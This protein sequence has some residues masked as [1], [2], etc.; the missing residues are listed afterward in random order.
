MFDSGINPNHVEFTGRIAAARLLLAHGTHP[1]PARP[2]GRRASDPVRSSTPGWLADGPPPNFSVAPPPTSRAITRVTNG[3]GWLP[4]R[5]QLPPRRSGAALG[6]R[7]V[8][9][10]RASTFAPPGLPPRAPHGTAGPPRPG[11]RR[12]SRWSPSRSPP[13]APRSTSTTPS[14]PRRRSAP[15][16]PSQRNSAG[17]DGP[18]S[19][20]G[21]ARH[22]DPP[23]QPV[24]RQEHHRQRL[25]RLHVRLRRPWRRR[26]A[27]TG[28]AD[29]R[30]SVAA[31]RLVKNTRPTARPGRRADGR[32]PQGHPRRP[33][34]QPVPAE[35]HDHHRLRRHRV[36]LRRVHRR[37]SS[38]P[39]ATAGIGPSRAPAGP[40]GRRPGRCAAP[41]RRPPPLPPGNSA[42]CPP[43]PRPLSSRRGRPPRASH[44]SPP[45]A[46]PTCAC[47]PWSADALPHFRVTEAAARVARDRSRSRRRR[48][49]DDRPSHRRRRRSVGVA[50][51]SGRVA[52]CGPPDL[53][54]RLC[55]G[56]PPSP[57]AATL[58]VPI[59]GRPG[60]WRVPRRASA[61]GVH[62]HVPPPGARGSGAPR[63]PTTRSATTS[64]L[65]CV[66]G[67][68][69]EGLSA[70]NTG[71][72]GGTVGVTPRR[73]R[74]RGRAA[75]RAA[76]RRPGRRPRAGR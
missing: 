13:S 34:W 62:D 32:R 6:D 68:S 28:T 2:R 21:P 1:R 31:T 19:G 44:L 74:A 45:V 10:R 65:G 49:L 22:A 24:L 3:T 63:I 36:R 48:S 76:G 23:R 26:P 54:P 64:L 73:A 67:A 58:G 29:T 53:P 25:R 72:L 5:L 27:A 15:R 66:A 16:T 70:H 60:A 30:P 7:G 42:A 41:L 39:M 33:S 38:G 18:P 56:R 57:V 51:G 17:P 20:R 52:P 75:R 43:H 40:A 4:E 37:G 50:P 9:L 8:R 69:N 55:P 59:E 47:S 71:A 11:P 46:P 14:R 12:R 61:T 35:E